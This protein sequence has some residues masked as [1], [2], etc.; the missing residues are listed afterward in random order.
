M[1]SK[2]DN[3]QMTKWLENDPVNFEE[4][5]ENFLKI[6]NC[7]SCYERGVVTSSYSG[8]LNGVGKWVYR[9]YTGWNLKKSDDDTLSIIKT[10]EA[11]IV[12]DASSLP[13]ENED[14]DIS[15]IFHSIDLTINLPFDIASLSYINMHLA[16]DGLYGGVMDKTAYDNDL[17]MI[18]KS[19][20][21]QLWSMKKEQPGSPKNKK[22][23]INLKGVLN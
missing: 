1:S 18:G 4:V 19:L 16:V 22:I 2:T 11:C 3:L 5:N 10:I 21:V 12:I 9:K 15:S 6:D 23:M 13:I 7:T 8:G 20:K 14:S 17:S